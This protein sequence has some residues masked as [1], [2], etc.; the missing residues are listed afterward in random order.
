MTWEKIKDQWQ[1]EIGK[2][3][4][5]ICGPCKRIKGERRVLFFEGEDCSWRFIFENTPETM[6]REAEN[7][8]RKA[9]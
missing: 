9:R 2:D 7:L 5:V 8:Y 1:L 4:V 6:Q 3:M